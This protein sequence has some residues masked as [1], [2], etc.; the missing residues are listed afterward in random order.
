MVLNHLIVRT[1]LP[2][3]DDSDEPDSSPSSLHTQIQDMAKEEETDVESLILFG[4][5]AL[6]ADEETVPKA[7]TS[8]EVDGMIEQAEKAEET[9]E[10]EAGGFKFG[11]AEVYDGGKEGDETAAN[12]DVDEDF[13]DAIVKRAAQEKAEREEAGRGARRAKVRSPHQLHIKSQTDP[14]A[15]LLL[16]RTPS[17]T[18]TWSTVLLG[19]VA[20]RPARRAHHPTT[21]ERHRRCRPT[22][23]SNR[24]P[25]QFT[26]RCRLDRTLRLRQNPWLARLHPPTL[27]RAL[28]L[29]LLDLVLQPLQGQLCPSHLLSPRD[30]PK[31]TRKSSRP[32]ATSLSSWLVTSMSTFSTR[33]RRLR[34]QQ[35]LRQRERTFGICR[36]IALSQRWRYS[37]SPLLSTSNPSFVARSTFTTTSTPCL[38]PTLPLLLLP[39]S[40]RFSFHPHPPSITTPH[41]HPFINST[42]FMI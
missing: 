39:K 36:S 33:S 15:V 24:P 25:I 6:F 1:L 22:R 29:L 42:D 10:V 37:A 20:S 23:S 26:S 8:E 17:P 5:K 19:T 3:G 13:W 21:L 9:V 31:Q 38:K 30:L 35:P 18:P 11:Y 40:R 4:A 7:Y 27:R 12:V 28:E 32:C 2:I 41:D 16:F 14:S 34:L